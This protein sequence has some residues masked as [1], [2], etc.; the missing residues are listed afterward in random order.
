MATEGMV[1]KGTL[2]EGAVAEGT[3]VEGTVAGTELAGAGAKVG[4]V[5][6]GIV[7]VP[8]PDTAGNGRMRTRLSKM[9]RWGDI[10]IYYLIIFQTKMYSLQPPWISR[11]N[12][13]GHIKNVSRRWKDNGQP[14]FKKR[15]AREF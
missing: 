7:P 2:P 14:P 4:A 10:C 1:S 6:A 13:P 3:M 9:R 11:K 5:I 15:S 8:W 12:M